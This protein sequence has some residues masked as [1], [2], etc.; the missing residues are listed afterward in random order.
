MSQAIS[1][2]APAAISN[3]PLSGKVA[4]IAGAA[5]NLG[6]AIAQTLAQAG[7]ATVVHYHSAASRAD[8]E[9]TVAAI[10]ANG[11]QAFAWQGDLTKVATI[12]ALFA[13]TIERFG[14]VD[15][16]VNAVGK[17]LKKTILETSEAEYDAM[18]AVNSKTAYFFMREAGKHLQ[19]GGKIINI[20]TSLLAAF[21]GHYGVYAGAKAPLEHFTRAAAKELGPRGISVNSVAPGPLDTPFFHEQESAQATAYLKSASMN[22]QLGDI[23][24]IAPIVKFLAT[25][26]WWIN[27]QTIFA[28]GGFATR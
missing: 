14:R 12:E 21:T 15:I 22:G 23:R 5:K 18:F 3:T 10:T 8:A 7:A 28:N 16:A 13:T 9:A 20:A 6:S 11:G 17:V 26:G 2:T 25:E 19:Q 4:V 1:D 24:D 27:G